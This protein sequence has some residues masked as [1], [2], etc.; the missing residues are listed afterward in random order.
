M[1]A[2][3]E[4]FVFPA[5]VGAQISMFSAVSSAVSHILSRHSQASDAS[6]DF[7]VLDLLC[8]GNPGDVQKDSVGHSHY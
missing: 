6:R 7:S 3:M 5:P 8:L 2:S 4:Q 1:M